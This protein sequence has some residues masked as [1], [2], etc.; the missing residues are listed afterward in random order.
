[1][2]HIE[3]DR[4]HQFAIEAIDLT[5][6]EN[7]HVEDCATCWKRLVTEIQL[8]AFEAAEISESRLVN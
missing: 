5:E 6:A 8:V 4:L 7:I 1:M 2:K 3:R